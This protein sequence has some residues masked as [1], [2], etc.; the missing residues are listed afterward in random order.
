MMGSL[1]KSTSLAQAKRQR[2]LSWCTWL[3]AGVRCK[4]SPTRRHRLLAQTVRTR[5]PA[6]T[7]RVSRG[8]SREEVGG[9]TGLR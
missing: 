6:K 3:G 7:G 5:Q 1:A 9:I 8:D 2:T 4:A